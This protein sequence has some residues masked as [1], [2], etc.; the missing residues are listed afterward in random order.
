MTEEDRYRKSI[1]DPI[2][3]KGVR[4]YIAFMNL[5]ITEDEKPFLFHRL[6]STS[7]KD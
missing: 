5:L 6:K 3:I 1:L 4:V 2:K 7:V